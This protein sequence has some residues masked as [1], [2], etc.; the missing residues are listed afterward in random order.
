MNDKVNRFGKKGIERVIAVAFPLGNIVFLTHLSN[1]ET[2][3]C[4]T[5]SKP[6]AAAIRL[7]LACTRSGKGNQVCSEILRKKDLQLRT[8]FWHLWK[9]KPEMK[10]FFQ[11]GKKIVKIS[12]K[13]EQIRT[14]FST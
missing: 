6:M 10:S 8:K 5:H 13:N 14:E 1:T 3:Y 7:L 9:G 12:E 2:P 4:P 11:F